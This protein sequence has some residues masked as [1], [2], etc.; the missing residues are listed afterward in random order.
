MPELKPGREQLDESSQQNDDADMVAPM[1]LHEVPNNDGQPG[2]RP[3]DLQWTS[4]QQTDHEPADDTGHDALSGRHARCD[5]DAHAERQRHQKFHDR[6][7]QIA[8]QIG[9]VQSGYECGP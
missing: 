2:R 3:A 5:G 7:E 9:E 4:C 8:A 6:C 1:R